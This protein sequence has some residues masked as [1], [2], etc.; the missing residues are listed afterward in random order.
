[1]AFKID[2]NT[3]YLNYHSV[4]IAQR[5]FVRQQLKKMSNYKKY[6]LDICNIL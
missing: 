6:S 4:M 1:M 3:D 5:D 2:P